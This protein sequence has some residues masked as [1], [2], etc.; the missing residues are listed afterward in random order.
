MAL[1]SPDSSFVGID[2]SGEQIAAGQTMLATLGLRNIELYQQSIL[3][4]S[5]SDGDFDYILCHGVFSWVP[6]P[7]QA[8]IL[9]ICQHQLS[10]NGIAYI[11]Y[12]THPGWHLRGLIRHMMSYHV[13]RYPQDPPHTRVARARRLLDF[14]ER[15]ARDRDRSYAEMLREHAELLRQLSDAY[16][17]HEH[18]EE[19]NDPVWFLDFCERLATHRLRFIAESE[20]GT[21]VSG[22]AFSPDVNQELDAMA[23][24]LYEKEQYMDFA[25]NRS[26]RQTLIGHENLQPDYG[27]SALRLRELLLASPVRMAGE[28]QDLSTGAQIEFTTPEGLRLDS[29]TPIVKAALACLGDVWPKAIPFNNLVAEARWRLLRWRTASETAAADESNDELTLARALLATYLR[30]QDTLVRLFPQLPP[31]AASVAEHPVASS[32]ARIQAQAGGPITNLRHEIVSVSPFDRHLLQLLDG[33]RNRVALLEAL[34][35]RF[36]RGDFKITQDEQP[37]TDEGRVRDILQQTLEKQLQFL[38]QA[39]LLWDQDWVNGTNRTNGT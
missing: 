28:E 12:N 5:A 22:I 10:S 30:A 16:L 31:F 11:S 19:H 26:F 1:V 36:R 25:R 4:L 6:P 20:M 17:F 33:T 15:A 2:L 39:A 3:D 18:L 34:I 23:S 35:E 7:V 8:K 38:V 14:L 13:S 32:L 29:S 24:N 27:L 21:M 9:E 37:V